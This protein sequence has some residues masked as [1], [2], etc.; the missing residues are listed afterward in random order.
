[1]TI[2]FIFWGLGL[3]AILLI[4]ALV[5]LL[6]LIALI[7]IIRSEFEGNNKLLWVLIVL[8]L[9]FLGS[10]LYFLLG[11]DQKYRRY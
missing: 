2:A 5:L 1:M 6:P 4:F 9:P 7:D 10:I 11:R 3:F 8:F